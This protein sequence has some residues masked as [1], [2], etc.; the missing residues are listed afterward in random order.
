MHKFFCNF[1]N[2]TQRYEISNVKHGSMLFTAKISQAENTLLNEIKSL[3]QE[4]YKNIVLV[5][6][7]E[8]VEN[9]LNILDETELLISNLYFSFFASPLELPQ[10][11]QS[12]TGNE[13][14]LALD[15]IGKLEKIINIPEYNRIIS[16]IRNNLSSLMQQ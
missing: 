16:I 15:I 9:R 12:T 1:N 7:K 10:H 3:L 14:S 6:E 13:L 8:K 11:D 5:K 4:L 2:L